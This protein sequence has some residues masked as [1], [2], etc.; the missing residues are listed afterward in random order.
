VHNDSRPDDSE[1]KGNHSN[2][3]AMLSE[4]EKTHGPY[5]VK[6]EIIQN[7]KRV[8][9]AY[10]GWHSLSD[11]QRESLDMIVHKIGRILSGDPNVAD[12]WDDIA[13]YAKLVSRDLT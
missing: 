13:G 12:H 8:M 4:R 11:V 3:E 6:A 9:T 10:A 1:R 5:K 2:T 7:L